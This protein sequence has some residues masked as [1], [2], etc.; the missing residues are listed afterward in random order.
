MAHTRQAARAIPS[1]VQRREYDSLS[2][3]ETEGDP[4]MDTASHQSVASSHSE[5]G[6]SGGH[7]VDHVTSRTEVSPAKT[8][9]GQGSEDRPP[10]VTSTVTSNPYLDPIFLKQLVKA[11]ATGMGA[12]ASNSTPR[13]ERVITLV[14]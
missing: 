9:G 1:P 6:D 4:L 12:G 13:A 14:Q 8:P 5:R 10:P 2:G 3:N 11:V 7:Q